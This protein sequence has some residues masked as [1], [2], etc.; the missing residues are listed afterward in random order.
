VCPFEVDAGVIVPF[1][2]GCEDIWGVCV[3]EGEGEEV[4]VF[5]DCGGVEEVCDGASAV[6]EEGV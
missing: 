1:E 2:D 5:A 3:C 4:P 6:Y